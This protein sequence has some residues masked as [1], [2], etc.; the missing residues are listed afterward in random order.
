MSPLRNRTLEPYRHRYLGRRCFILATG[1]SVAN[2]DISWLQS[3][4]VIGVNFAH[5]ITL[6][7]GWVPT[8]MV[9]AD[10]G[11][12][13]KVSDEWEKLHTKVIITDTCTIRCGYN[14]PNLA[15][16]GGVSITPRGSMFTFDLTKMIRI[17][18][19]SSSV[20]YLAIPLACFLGCNPIYLLGCDCTERGHAY[21]DK[22]AYSP[23][24]MMLWRTKFMPAMGRIRQALEPLGI[25]IYNATCGGNLKTLERVD[26]NSLK[27][28]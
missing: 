20:G 5:K 15:S 6:P 12:L 23:R 7:Q 22:G 11:I 26:F 18:A 10:P 25:K 16:G 1:P 21:D 17:L 2:Q 28:R 8:F 24:A 13:N 3:E 27:G 14:A 19:G 9:T 4:I